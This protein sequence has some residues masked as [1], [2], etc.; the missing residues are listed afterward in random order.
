MNRIWVVGEPYAPEENTTAYYLTQTAEGLAKK[1]PVAVLCGQPSYLSRGVRA[2]VT[3]NRNQV[4][5]RRCRGTTLDKNIL[6][7]RLSNMV[8]LG[9]SM[10]F[11]ALFRIRKGDKVLVVTAP[12]TLPFLI[13][14]ACRIK[15]VPYYFLLHDKYPDILVATGNASEGSIAVRLM[16]LLN[17]WLYGGAEKIITVGRDME[18][19]VALEP[20]ADS[21]RIVTIQNWASLE[22]VSPT[23]RSENELL[24]ELGLLE[25]FV[26]LYAGNMGPPQDIESIVQ[27]ATKLKEDK[28]EDVHFLFVGAGAKK[29]WLEGK[30]EELG[31]D[32]VSI[33][34]PRPRTD[35]TNF[36]NA[37]DVAVVTLVEGM[38]ALAMP[39]RT[40]NFLAAAKPIIAIVEEGSEPAIVVEEENVGWVVSP[41]DPES[42]LKAIEHASN[43]RGDL[44]EMSER[45]LKAARTKYSFETALAK[46]TDAMEVGDG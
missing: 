41:H 16:K 45:A 8:T 28:N 38:K 21:E 10:F 4:E 3:E 23:E 12:P 40:Y 39:S 46:Y 30:K 18:E 33:V 13:A 24:K 14:L 1:T 11:N 31:L 27:A 42:L 36:L 26:V 34:G 37:C 22:E 9:T 35:Q 32:N 7:F 20:G 29:N 19:A 17:K 2:P 15:R 43:L 5:V 25:K 6:A 44:V